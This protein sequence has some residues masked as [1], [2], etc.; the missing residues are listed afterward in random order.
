LD[1]DEHL[2]FDHQ[3]FRGPGCESIGQDHEI[4]SLLDRA[5][6][7]VGRITVIPGDGRRDGFRIEV[8]RIAEE[9]DLDRG[10]SD[11]E[12]HGRSIADEMQEFD[13]G[14]CQYTRDTVADAAPRHGDDHALLHEDFLEKTRA[15]SSS[16]I[17]TWTRLA[18]L[19]FAMRCRRSSASTSAT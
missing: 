8:H 14:H 7:L 5:V 17:A 19:A 16:R 13:A 15:A 11:D 1:P 3:P 2:A 10:N 4:S 6:K 9:H 18:S 12:R